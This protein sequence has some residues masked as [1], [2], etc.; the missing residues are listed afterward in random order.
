MNVDW[1]GRGRRRARALG[2][3]LAVMSPAIASAQQPAA[4]SLPAAAL[5]LDEA[6]RLAM[7][8]SEALQ[9]A[10]AG[11]TRASGQ[12]KQARSQYLPQ[13][14]SNLAYARALRSQFSAL[15]SGSPDSSTTTS[16]PKPQSVCAP[17]IAAN[18]TPA[19]RA[20]ALAQASTCAAAQGID[21][22]KVGFGARNSYTFGL[23]LSQSVYSG[24][25]VAGQ[26]AA[27]AAIPATPFPTGGRRRVAGGRRSVAGGRRSVA[28]GR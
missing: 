21:F 14:N 15:A 8:E 23:A 28:S 1:T 22:S 12:L 18:A 4:G 25:R 19:E 10:R 9:I 20:A 5:S 24:G 16:A 27:A 13:L 17:Q 7:R 11:I 2:L 3:L 26:T 6:I